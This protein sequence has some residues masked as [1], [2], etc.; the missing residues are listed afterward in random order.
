MAVRGEEGGRTR[1]RQACLALSLLPGMDPRTLRRLCSYHGSAAAAWER[2][3]ETPP[4]LLGGGRGGE[5]RQGWE[6]A[7]RS[8]DPQEELEKLRARGIHLVLEGEEGYPPELGCIYDPPQAL[9]QWGEARPGG[10][11][12][13]VVGSRRA[14]AQGRHFAERLGAELAGAGIGVVSGGAYGVDAAA[15]LGALR[16]GGSNW[17]VL[18]HGLEHVYPAEHRE[19]FNRIRGVGGLIS[20]YAPAVP[21]AAWHFPERNRIIAG[22]CSGVVVV[23]GSERSGALITAEYAM[24]EGREVFAVPG[25]LAN[26]LTAAPHRLI[27]QGAKLITCLDDVLEELGWEVRPA[28]ERSGEPREIPGDIPP[29]SAEESLLLEMLGSEP[30]SADQLHSRFPGQGFYLALSGLMVKGLVG[31]EAGGRFVRLHNNYQ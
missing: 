16:V 5:R 28:E 20:E 14:S 8:L 29:L 24:E 9:Y 11:L 12:L 18:G 3:E 15:H 30:V 13:A 10:R 26:P 17:A 25:S 4:A 7:R 19:L 27:Q 23:E 2:L 6:R 22:M 31:E 1:E 21:P